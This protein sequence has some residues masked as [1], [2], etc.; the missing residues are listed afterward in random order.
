MY[1]KVACCLKIMLKSLIVCENNF[2]EIIQKTSHK[3]PRPSKEDPRP[4]KEDPRPSKEAPRPKFQIPSP[5]EETKASCC[6]PLGT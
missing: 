4:P 2:R 1:N 6:T 5:K 3:D